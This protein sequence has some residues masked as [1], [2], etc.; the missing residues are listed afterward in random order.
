MM[1]NNFYIARDL[2]D[3]YQRE[4]AMGY[5]NKYSDSE[6]SELFRSGDDTAFK[7][8][9]DRYYNLLYLF[10]YNKL[11]NTEEA[12][13][14]VHDMFAWMIDHRQKFVLK[15]SLSSYLYKSVLNKVFNIFSHQA[16]VRKYIEQG[17]YFIEVDSA[18]TDYLIREKDIADMISQEIANMPPK[19]REVY[20]LKF[21]GYLSA[22]DIAAKLDISENTVNT[23]LKRAVKK[24]RDNLG[25]AVFV[26]YILNK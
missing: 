14:A 7:E 4:S 12:K 11:R 20:E 9:Y 2:A 26:L 8:I 6:L 13:D 21:N 17:D 18:E 23:H 24:L 15:T 5:Y 25:A 1:P 19:M 10:A 16:I 22:K 3:L